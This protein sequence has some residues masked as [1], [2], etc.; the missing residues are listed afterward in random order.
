MN[1]I[2]VFNVYLWKNKLIK[3]TIAYILNH[4]YKFNSCIIEFRNTEPYN[5]RNIH[6]VQMILIHD[7]GKK[8]KLKKIPITMTIL[9]KIHG[10]HITLN[11]LVE[12]LSTSFTMFVI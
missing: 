11:V 5:I 1:L 4:S 10:I 12:H 2:L 9:I 8:R 3:G 6:M 7:F